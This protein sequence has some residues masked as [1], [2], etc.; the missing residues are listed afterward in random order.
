[1]GAIT[2][3]KK[4]YDQATVAFFQS[5]GWQ[6]FAIEKIGKVSYCHCIYAL[7]VL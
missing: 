7:F 2:P 6:A 5:C 4:L 3:D 1:M